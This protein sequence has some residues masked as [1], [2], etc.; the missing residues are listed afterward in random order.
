M[1]YFAVLAD[2]TLIESQ[3]ALH[4]AWRALDI[5]RREFVVVLGGVFIALL[6]A[7]ALANV[8]GMRA[9][10][11]FAY[12]VGDRVR[13]VLFGGYLRRDYL[14]H[15]RAGAARLLD[16]VLYQADRV[17]VSLLNGQVLITN[18]VLTLLVVVSIAV[19]SPV[20]ALVGTLT[21]GGSYL[22]CFRFVQRRIAHNGRLQT[23][24]GAERMA[25][26]EQAFL[27]IK[28][29][30]VAQAQDFYGR[31]FDAV[32]RMFSRTSSDT[33]FVGQFPRYVLECVAGAALIACAA[34]V[35]GRSTG[36]AWLAQLG[37]IGFAGFRLL[38]AFQQMYY[39]VVIIRAQRAGVEA[40]ASQLEMCRPAPQV[41]EP[42]GTP[43]RRRCCKPSSWPAC[44]FDTRPSCRWS[45]KIP[46]CASPPGPRSE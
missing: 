35:S 42:G 9:M 37:F 4:W 26:V 39:A 46:R 40:L 1:A 32:F 36:S 7:S 14:F 28:Y 33:Q 6:G 5:T 3:A 16:D 18:A 21:V 10:G 38:P 2:P 25:V 22:L 29:L 23:Q 45:W 15:V 43:N 17:T 31:R 13:A 41:R 11:R 30:M 12:S 34:F 20:V 27:S 24:F 19:V 8:F 44:R